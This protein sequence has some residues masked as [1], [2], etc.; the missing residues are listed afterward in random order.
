VTAKPEQAEE[1]RDAC[2]ETLQAQNTK[3]NKILLFKKKCKIEVSG[4]KPSKSAV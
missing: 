3:K 1:A 2:K 4:T